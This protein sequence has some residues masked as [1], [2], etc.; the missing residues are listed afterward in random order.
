MPSAPGTAA[1][2]TETVACRYIGS[3]V[4]L[5]PCT[6]DIGQIHEVL[7][8][9]L[10]HNISV[11]T[12]GMHAIEYGMRGGGNGESSAHSV[13]P[14]GLGVC[15]SDTGLT[16]RGYRGSALWAPASGLSRAQPAR[17]GPRAYH[18]GRP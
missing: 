4:I 13:S 9:V 3:L 18:R 1:R 8:Q 11:T 10:W 2:G 5:F 17:H 6:S 16:L 15:L 12:R 14:D 7:C